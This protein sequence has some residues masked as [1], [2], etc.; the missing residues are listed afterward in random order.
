MLRIN[1][2]MGGPSAE[3]E[4][5]L[6]TGRE[7]LLHINRSN[8]TLR[9]VVVNHKK[10]FYFSDIK[11]SIPDAA[12]LADPAGSPGFSGPFIPSDS[13]PVWE[14]CDAALLA[15]HGSFGED[16]VFQ[17]FL[18]TLGIPYTGSGVFAS[19][20]SMDKI[21]SKR[22]FI[23]VGLNTP[24]YSIFGKNHTDLTPAIIAEKHG[25]PCFVK[26]PQSGSSRLMGAAADLS[27]LECLLNEL[28][29]SSEEILVETAVK[30]EEYS[31]PVLERPDGTLEALPPVL[32]RPLKSAFFDFEAKYTKGASEEIVPAP[33][34]GSV[35]KRIKQAALLAHSALHCRGISR[36]DMI[37][38]NDRLYVL[39]I[40]TLPGLTTASLVP[41]SFA[42]AGGNY[43]ELLDIL[44]MAAVSGKRDSGI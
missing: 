28:S 22:I 15:L 8:Y 23:N 29:K 40:N 39:E 11:D 13:G 38:E 44:I 25:F 43:A 6:L 3:H 16:G 27:E 21:A 17:G 42:A 24:P 1:V 10:E 37:L 30:G 34:K 20:V 36:T 41:K 26:C 31:C 7:I 33:V 14:G 5:S 32:I 18:E 12:D 4:I 9:A 19:S 2:V 35:L